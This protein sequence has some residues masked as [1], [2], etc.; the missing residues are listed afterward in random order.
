MED[1]SVRTSVQ[2][3]EHKKRLSIDTLAQFSCKRAS[4]NAQQSAGR[5]IL[6]LL[7]VAIQKKHAETKKRAQV[8]MTDT[9]KKDKE[10]R[11]MEEIVEEEDQ[12]IQQPQLFSDIFH[13]Q[14]VATVFQ[15][16]KEAGTHLLHAL[17]KEQLDNL[18][19]DVHCS[20][21]PVVEAIRA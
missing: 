16:L 19:N 12:H 3:M 1:D 11:M 15:P 20:T 10:E 13:N 17:P 5:K 21:S 9:R 6:R 4:N 7:Q 2:E 14:M 18:L 8:E